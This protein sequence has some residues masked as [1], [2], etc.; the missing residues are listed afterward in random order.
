MIA[1]IR[2]R[3]NKADPGISTFAANCAS[4]HGAAGGGG[5]GPSLRMAGLA[6]ASVAAIVKNGKGAMPAFPA[7][8]GK[9][10]DALLTLVDG[11]QK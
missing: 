11:W 7:I 3:Q 8:T 4:C 2:S 6:R 9:S 1:A 5:I 10:F